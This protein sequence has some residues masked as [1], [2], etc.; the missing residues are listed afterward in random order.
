MEL[1]LL[2]TLVA[3]AEHGTLTEAALRLHLTQPALT[4]QVRQ[5]EKSLGLALFE[6]VGR[7]LALTEAG[8][9]AVARGRAILA[10][11][12]GL[13][14][15]ARALSSLE[16]GT[17]RLGGGTTAVVHLLPSI[18]QAFR[19]A[20]PGIAFYLKEGHSQGIL[21]D[22]AVG[23]LD[24]GIVT[25]PCRANGVEVEPWLEDE[26]V[27]V[28]WPGAPLAVRPLAM[29]ELTGAPFIHA[30]PDSPLRQAVEAL[31]ALHGV[32]VETAMELQ[33]LEAIKAHAASGLGYAA[34]G[35]RSVER[36]IEEGRLVE[37]ETGLELSR[38]L[39]LAFRKSGTQAPAVRAF[40]Q[41]L[42]GAHEGV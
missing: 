11:A 39:G 21:E 9:R 3:I 29:A 5:L 33:S 27:L 22:V 24:L 23:R 37:L 40:L 15:E 7:R 36:E 18:I 31:F 2:R 42:R 1:A 10:E 14:E 26:I 4:H 19:T 17:V 34:V 35:R 16:T 25:C 30:E 13:L 8:E 20:H 41:A 12:D 6:R 32:A 38:R 28:A